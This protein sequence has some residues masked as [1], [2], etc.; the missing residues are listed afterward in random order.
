MLL[1]TIK[2]IKHD[3]QEFIGIRFWAIDTQDIRDK[4]VAQI[5]SNKLYLSEVDF[6][7]A[8]DP[9]YVTFA[10]L[11]QKGGKKAQQ[12]Y[13]L[14]RQAINNFRISCLCSENDKHRKD[15]VLNLLMWAHYARSHK[16][17]CVKYHIIPQIHMVQEINEDAENVCM[18]KPIVYQDKRLNSDDITLDEAFFLKSS[19]WSYENE[20]RILFYSPSVN[21]GR[22]VFLKTCIEGVYLGAKIDPKDRTYILNE[23]HGSSIPLYQMKYNRDDV[24]RITPERI[25]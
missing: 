19:Q 23:L 21:K 12:W 17:V 8:V 7:D 2:S 6:N 20:H 9:L 22:P 25:L 18:L 15:N 5:K 1:K 13:R 16:G 4:L 11:H 24:L 3:N 14:L 10:Q